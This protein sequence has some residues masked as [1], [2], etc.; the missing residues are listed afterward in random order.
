MFSSLINKTV[1]PISE[2]ILP[3]Q[4]RGLSFQSQAFGHEI[5]Q[6]HFS[7]P[8]VL[9]V[10]IDGILPRV[11]LAVKVPESFPTRLLSNTM[12]SEVNVPVDER[13]YTCLYTRLYKCLYICLYICPSVHRLE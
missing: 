9:A 3:I 11:V 2:N 12:S 4:N 13:L 1:Q 10:C 5:A 6:R 7:G 8:V